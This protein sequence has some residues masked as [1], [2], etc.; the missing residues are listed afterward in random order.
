MSWMLCEE[1]HDFRA[2]LAG[3]FNGPKGDSAEERK[4]FAKTTVAEHWKKI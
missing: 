2:Q 3:L 4:N 1:A